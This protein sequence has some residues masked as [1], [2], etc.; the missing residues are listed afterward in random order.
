MIRF[1]QAGCL[2]LLFYLS[3]CASKSKPFFT[4]EK[5]LESIAPYQN[6]TFTYKSSYPHSE[7]GFLE[8]ESDLAVYLGTHA[9]LIM[10]I[11]DVDQAEVLNSLE[12]ELEV[13]R[14]EED[15]AG[16]A[17][18]EQVLLMDFRAIGDDLTSTSGH[19]VLYT[20]DGYMLT[21]AHAVENENS[22]LVFRE[23][24]IQEETQ[25]IRLLPF[26]KV[27]VNDDIDFAIIKAEV[28]T[29][30]FLKMRAEAP[31]FKD[32][33]F[34]GGWLNEVPAAGQLM[35]TGKV[36]VGA[37]LESAGATKLVSDVPVLKGDSGS[38]LIDEEGWLCGIQTGTAV[39]K[40][41]YRKWRF[42]HA[43]YL[44]P[45]FIDA[46]IDKDRSEFAALEN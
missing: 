12:V 15:A 27:Y 29:P 2:L 8:V 19:G 30:F 13:E 7:K 38:A 39:Y 28:R 14:G 40:K 17:S 9:C 10:S 16:I 33:V 11:K 4:L 24:D 42:S 31:A 26:R 43:I 37:V 35:W 23:Y 21:A 32:I 41:N 45:E 18:E 22:I 25:R 6:R 1:I 46:I 44:K 36:E 34:G 3:G 20:E 5:R